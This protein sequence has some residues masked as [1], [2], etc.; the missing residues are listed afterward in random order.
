MAD[1]AIMGVDWRTLTWW[2]YQALLNRWNAR[3]QPS[4]PKA[5]PPMPANAD[6]ILQVMSYH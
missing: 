1:C 5:P 4:D 6:R 2:E 3:S